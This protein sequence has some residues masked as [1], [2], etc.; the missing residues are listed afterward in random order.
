MVL[1]DNGGAWAP[2]TAQV[3][4]EQLREMESSAENIKEKQFELL[5]KL[6]EK[7][8]SQNENLLATLVSSIPHH[9]EDV[10]FLE[11]AGRQQDESKR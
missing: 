6:K 2:Q 7:Y 9:L 11:S 5:Q 4:A 1:T 10:S 3:C 8:F